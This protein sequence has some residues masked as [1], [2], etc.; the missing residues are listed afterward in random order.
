M[1]IA[2]DIAIIVVAGLFG[3][4]IA[5]RLRQ[6]L[7]LGYILA[8][9]MVGPFTIG[10][11]VSDVHDIELLAEIG[12]A[13]LLFALG[14]EFSLK[15][16]QP[17][18]KI[19]LIG[20]PIQLLLTIALGYGIGQLLDWDWFSSL[21][22]GGLISLSS[23]MVALKTLMSQGRMGTLSSRVMIGILI[24]QDLAVVPLMI[25]LPEL[26]NPEAGLPI[27]GAAA[28]K[29]V[30]FLFLMVVV[31]TRIIPQLV[32]YVARWNSRELFLVAI[33]AIGLGV[34]YA[35]YLFG[36]SFAFG[37]FVAGIV[38]SESDYGHQALSDIIP[39]RDV[40]GLLFFVSVGML[41]DPRFVIENWQMV[42]LVVLLVGVGKA[43]I[44]GTLS[45]LFS[46]GNIVPLAVGLSLFQAGEF[47]FV[48]ARVGINTNSIS[49]D[50]YAFT[51]TVAVVTMLFTPLVSGLAAP[52]YAWRRRRRF[53]REPLQT[54]NLPE[55]E[56]G[57]H[58]VI[59]GG[60]RVGL[61]VAHVVQQ[62]G[63]GLVLIELDQ[64][65]VEQ[66][67]QA[68][69]PVIYG[70]ASQEVVLEAAHVA[71][72]RL[73]LV[74]TPAIETTH[75]IVTQVN[76]LHPGVHIVAR[77][78]GVEA[79]QA[80]QEQGVYEVVQSEFE[81]SLEITR[82][83]LLHFDISP[84]EIQKFTDTIRQK[85]YA[86]LYE[87]HGKYQVVA[88]LQNATRLLEV[89]WVSLP[90]GSSLVGQTIEAAKVRTLTGASV[91]G[92]LHEGELY[93]NPERSYRFSEGDWVAVMG[94]IEQLATFQTL[95]A[96]TKL[97]INHTTQG[98][99]MS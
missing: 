92:I 39:L 6:P 37:A 72:A 61:Y 41:L 85:L 17:V 65:R 26:N 28:L 25:I 44:F 63:L 10:P 52:L 5:Q 31:G 66:A 74:T 81:A 55:K 47:S 84:T 56:L 67:K 83:A 86:P 82:Q 69:L 88:Q 91:V 54:I 36:L 60:G 90:A 29:A 24:V 95:A 51:L 11:T 64:R 80:L 30:L 98:T 76:R 73:V 13:L 62:L 48:L 40:F 4:L 34:G 46:Y 68:Q 27:L 42:L 45:K 16:L 22:F 35:T 57:D 87:S 96:S 78:E 79:M 77:A 59:A 89:S 70:D 1:G 23:T 7:L 8:G 49:E 71:H 21:W 99:L 19:A 38:L 9:I 32:S 97:S 15:E 3:G 2:A 18:R 14:L 20:T 43:V 58:I 53:G 94:N 50:L 12:V 33:T 75:A 93:A